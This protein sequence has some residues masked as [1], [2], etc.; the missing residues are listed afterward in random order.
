VKL[1]T[2]GALTA[3]VTMSAVPLPS[4]SPTPTEI[5]PERPP[6]GAN[7]AITCAPVEE[8]TRTSSAPTAVPA[9]MSPRESP[10]TFP[11]ATL[12]PPV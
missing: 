11:T 9:T 12:T 1:R 6:Y 10:A 4:V 2:R 8:K 3:S 7:G 5:L